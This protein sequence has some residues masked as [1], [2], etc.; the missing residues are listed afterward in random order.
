MIRLAIVGVGGYGWGPIR[1]LGAASES[2]GCRLIAAADT[3]LQDL[4]ERVEWLQDR[5][6]RLYE[7][8]VKM[9]EDLRGRCEGVYIASSIPSHAPLTVA[10]ARCGFH[11][12]LEKPPAATV[13]E[14]D[15]M[16]TALDR[17]RR[18]CLVGFQ[19]MHGH[20]RLVLDSLAAG[21]LGRVESLTCA[22]GWPRT[23]EYYRRNDWAGRLR[24]GERW[25]L[26]G[27]VT[28]ALAH[29]LAHMLAMASGRANA[30]AE[31]V[32]VRAEL[33]AAGPFDSHN[34][35]AIEV[36]TAEGPVVRFFCSHATQGQFG[37][38]IDV[39]A[40]G[41]RAA[42]AH[43]KQSRVTCAD[44]TAE[45]RPAEPTETRNMLANFLD[46]LR[47]DDPSLL[48]CPLAE[49][50]KYVTALDAAHDSSGCVHRI[51]ERYWHLVDAGTDSERVVVDGLDDVLTAANERGELFSELPDAPAWAVAP[52]AFDVD[53]YREFPRR[54]RCQ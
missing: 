30:L 27:P 21:R 49:T 48:R 39:T 17:A 24:L 18:M 25:V 42:Y 35:A 20:L 38:V 34:L 19:A 1:E 28:N 40:D 41:G 31:P 12:L 2:L 36:R 33:Y 6:V 8:A 5:S 43:G 4:P 29:Q 52:E 50:R 32:S 45:T 51:D 54:F 26:D 53:E 11:V 22:A 47:A 13:Q 23:R 3:R 10:A 44:G 7:D 16:L 14:V 9:F 15:D 46:A 37:P